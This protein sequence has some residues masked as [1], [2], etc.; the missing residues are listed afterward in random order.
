MYERQNA[1]G[2]R[3]PDLKAILRQV[4]KSQYRNSGG[5]ALVPGTL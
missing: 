4:V 3:V 1:Y 2:A 5:L